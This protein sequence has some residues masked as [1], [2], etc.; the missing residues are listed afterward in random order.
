MKCNIRKID[1]KIHKFVTEINRI[2]NGY[3]FDTLTIVDKQEI[4]EL[5]GEVMKTYEGVIYKKISKRHDLEN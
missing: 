4:V 1:G 3:I 2:R 5:G